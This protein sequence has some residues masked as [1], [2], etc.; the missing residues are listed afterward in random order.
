MA[1]RVFTFSSMKSRL[2]P[3]GRE[4]RVHDARTWWEGLREVVDSFVDADALTQAG[5][6]AF[7]AGLALAPLLT[8][9]VWF[10]QLFVGEEGKAQVLHVCQELL[11]PAAAA[12]LGDLLGPA[13]TQ[14]T[15][16]MHLAGVG[17]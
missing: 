4:E 10:T 11:G 3:A 7:Y 1:V 17:S 12:P 16:S 9:A 14:A 8:I 13:S 6:L 15:D 2:E 5:A